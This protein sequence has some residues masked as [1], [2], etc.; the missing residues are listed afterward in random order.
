[1]IVDRISSAPND[2][3]M[4]DRYHATVLSNFIRGYDK[5]SRRYSKMGI[6]ESTYPN[7]FFLLRREELFIGIE[8]ATQLVTRTSLPG[9]QVL[10]LQTRVPVHDLQPNLR[11]HVGELVE[12]DFINIEALFFIDQ[13]QQLHRRTV[14]EVAAASLACRRP[15]A[16]SWAE[17]NPRTVS[18]LPIARGCQA[19][20]DFCFS[21]AS[22][23]KNVRAGHLD[24][25]RV[26]A[27]LR[28]GRRRGA[29]RAVITGGGEPGL[30]AD[31]ELERL[32]SACAAEYPKVVLITNGHAL[33]RRD[34]RER[35]DVLDR[36]AKAGLTV[37]ALSRH[38]HHRADNARIMQ[39]DTNTETLVRSWLTQRERLHPLLLRLVCVLQ[40]GGIETATEVDAY[41]S[42][43]A[44]MGVREVCFKELYVSTSQE[45]I[46]HSDGANAWSREHQVPLRL[47]IDRAVHRSWQRIGE[48][49]WGAPIFSADVD[50]IL[51][52]IAAYTEPSVSWELHNGI[53]RS[54]NLMADGLCLASLEDRSSVVPVR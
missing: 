42:W 17:L 49:P 22:V 18:L 32:V 8:K 21:Q 14:E 46:Y 27:V 34:D 36:L 24:A 23:S 43:A 28:E 13:H 20:C 45:S 37:L 29:E 19:R 40:R 51:M 31:S 33:A 53:C 10:I 12:Q 4:V 7:R 6:P 30:L 25:T 11:T 47:I 38:H 2:S 16:R 44:S 50:G 1:M 3:V 52:K 26:S 9:D 48:L 35:V 54:W 41:L 15:I 5:Y 39:L